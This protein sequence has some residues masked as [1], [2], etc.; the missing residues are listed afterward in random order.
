MSET[1]TT[2]TAAP[3]LT[4]GQIK[5]LVLGAE[6]GY[7]VRAPRN[8]GNAWR[9]ADKLIE[10]G[11][12]SDHEGDDVTITAEGFDRIVA[13]GHFTG[14]RPEVLL[15]PA[16]AEAAKVVEGP[17]VLGDVAAVAPA[18]AELREG[19][20][21]VTAYTETRDRGSVAVAAPVDPDS[22]EGVEPKVTLTEPDGPVEDG[23]GQ[24]LAA[25]TGLRVYHTRKIVGGCTG[26]GHRHGVMTGNAE[27]RGPAGKERVR[28]EVILDCGHRVWPLQRVLRVEQAVE[29]KAA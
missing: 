13:E 17:I 2:T 7:I 4:S 6:T 8:G 19:Q 27:K 18:E 28:A 20:D 3:K 29:A 9:T 5:A 23:E 21:A 15:T 1:T 11:Y 22:L 12:A 26:E 14:E 24:I 25:V 16:E 10:F